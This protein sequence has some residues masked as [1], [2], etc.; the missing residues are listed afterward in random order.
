MITFEECKI[1]GY[2]AR[3]I[4]NCKEADITIAIAKDFSTYG[5]LLTYE[6]TVKANKEYIQVSILDDFRHS[7]IYVDTKIIDQIRDLRRANITLHIAGNGMY[8]L[9]TLGLDI[10]QDKLNELVLNY[11]STIINNVGCNISIITGG[12]T[13]IDEAGAKAGD[14]LKL[15]TKVLAPKGYAFR[16]INGKDIYN[17]ELFKARFK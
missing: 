7:G 8:T 10:T 1:N 4:Q 5:E 13:G 17:E 14:N 15:K 9:K 2:R 6:S 11:V 3:T 16:D 12:Q